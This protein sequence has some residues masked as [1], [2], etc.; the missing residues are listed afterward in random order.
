M[1][2]SPCTGLWNLCS[3]SHHIKLSSG[4]LWHHL[5]CFRDAD[6]FLV[7]GEWIV[8]ASDNLNHRRNSLFIFN[9]TRGMEV[10][11][12]GFLS[13]LYHVSQLPHECASVLGCDEVPHH[14]CRLCAGL[15]LK[16]MA[17][18]GVWVSLLTM[19]SVVWSTGILPNA[20][21]TSGHLSYGGTGW[22]LAIP[23]LNLMVKELIWAGCC[24][25]LETCLKVGMTLAIFKL[26]GNI[27]CL[28]VKFIMYV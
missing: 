25:E 5:N 16:L 15:S 19:T 21:W 27:P 14:S 20:L 4:L 1:G 22:L 7:V 6:K 13:W 3:N 11:V 18:P 8:P 26:S 2:F 24:S 23:A 9:D 28:S 10:S 12:F 17:P